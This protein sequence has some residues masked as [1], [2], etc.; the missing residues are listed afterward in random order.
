MSRKARRSV[1]SLVDEDL[2]TQGLSPSRPVVS[3]LTLLRPHRGRL[4]V[5][6][7]AFIIKDSPT[8]VL[9]PVTAA[10]IDV[11]VSRGNVSTV[12]L[13][14]G[15]ALVLLL[16]NYPFQMVVVRR[17]SEA[18]RG[19]AFRV[20]AG[21]ASSLQR[22]SLG[23]RNRMSAATVQTKIVRDVENLEL[24]L[25]QVLPTVLSA[26][27]TLT[28][29]IIVTALNVPQFVVV[30]A[31]VLPFAAALVVG[32][33]KRAASTN[34]RF[35]EEVELLSAQVSEMAAL[36]PITRSHGLEDVAVAKVAQ[37][38]ALVEQAG[39]RLD[40]LNGRFGALSWITYQVLGLTCLATAAAL[41]I[42]GTIEISAGQVVLLS[43]YFTILTNAIVMLLSIAPIVAKGLDAMRSIASVAQEFEIEPASGGKVLEGLSGDISL[44][45]VTVTYD[46]VQAPALKNF[47]LE[48]KAG[49]T[50]ALVGPSGSGKSTIV[51]VVLG[52]V[53]PV[54]G[55]V[56]I[57]GHDVKELDM[58]SV[59]RNVSIVPQETVLLAGSVRDNVAYGLADVEDEAIWDALEMAN[60]RAM[61]KA[62]PAGLDTQ[63]SERGSSL[64][65]G[66]RQRLAIA[67]ALVRHPRIL[68]LD[69]ATSALDSASE[70]EVTAALESASHGR[71]TLVVA[72][73]LSTIRHADRIVVVQ[74]GSLAQVGTH[75]ELIAA[76]GLY[77]DMVNAQFG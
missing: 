32:I 20:R 42:W 61:V 59:R 27:A 46:D 37:R 71:T 9:P 36:A 73:R 68:V 64:S 33:R 65:G 67:R 74:D 11:V 18:A 76:G 4:V 77:A 24:M 12:A 28:G 25:A 41:S 58:R 70:A 51:N 60:A 14:A 63:L 7:G 45:G 22:L 75:E 10:I 72:H 34:E 15:A 31:V 3:L 48:I 57:D 19:L 69:E 52:F 44:A 56:L 38:A 30:F 47:S 6:A 2:L 13:W 21:L 55:A 17:F 8:W 39:R 62:W 29:A 50:V 35:R 43:T 1:E 66:Q 16:L 26:A 23:S 40:V 53:A 54:S 49:E 5:G